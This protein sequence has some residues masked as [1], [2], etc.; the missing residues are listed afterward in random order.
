MDVPSL[1][2]P[3]VLFV[4]FAALGTL[5]C[6]SVRRYWIRRRMAACYGCQPVAKSLNREPFLGLD[7]IPSLLRAISQHTLLERICSYFRV[8]GNTFRLKELQRRAILT[9][10]PDNIKTVL[11]LKFEDY[12]VSYRLNAFRPLLGE[13]IFDTDGDHWAS[14]RTLIRPS[15]ARDQVADL[16]TLEDLVQDLFLLLPRDGETTVDLW[17][18]SSTTPSTRPP[19]SCSEGPWAR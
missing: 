3:S 10:E 14:S 18:S 2:R 15:F 16:T 11:S 1:F 17:S 19:T 13:G 4:L 9:I 6:V 7:T 8:Y 12:G 5:A